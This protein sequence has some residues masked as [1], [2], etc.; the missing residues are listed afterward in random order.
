MKKVLT[1]MSGGVDSSVTALLLMQEGF[2]VAGVN[3]IMHQNTAEGAC[4]SQAEVEIA[5]TVCENLGIDFYALDFQKE[6]SDNVIKNFIETYENGATPN[7]CVVCNRYVKFGALLEKADEMGFD[8]IAT[9][10]YAQIEHS[11]DRYLLKTAEDMTK[12]QSYVLYSLTQKQLSRTFFPLGKYKKSDVRA[13]AEENGFV[14]A[15]KHDS[16]DICFIPDGDYAAYIERA[17]GKTFPY[18]DFVTLDGR[19]LGEHKGIIKYT[20]GQRRGLGLALAL[21]A[22]MYVYKKDIEN[23]RVILGFNEDLFSDELVA[24]DVNFIPFDKLTSP[25]KVKVRVRYKQPAQ[26]ATIEQLDDGKVYV[27]FDTPQRA[28]AKGQ[29][30]VFYDGEYVVGGGVIE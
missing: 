2:Q 12:D 15:H 19:V 10:H 18:G 24:C 26:P 28:I 14:N 7:P 9:G 29:S 6:F 27:K 13:I 30:A 23:N 5:R 4:G 3:L 1:G 22:S 8:A 16:Q 25:M 11:G 21:P 20:V 17:T